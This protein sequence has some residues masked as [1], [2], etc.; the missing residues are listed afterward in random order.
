MRAPEEF[1]RV[2]VFCGGSS[3]EREISLQSGAAVT[4]GLV[5]AGIDTR[6][7]DTADNDID[8][9]TFDRVF[10]ALH[11]R[12]GEDGKIQAVLDYYHIPY[13]GSRVPASALSMNKWYTKSV[14]QSIGVRTPVYRIVGNQ[15]SVD[16]EDVRLPV[17][18]K[19]VNEGSSIGVAH[20][21]EIGQLQEAIS[22]AMQYDEYVL[23]EAAISGKEY[24]YSFIDGVANMPI[25]CLE[26]ATGFYD[27]DAKYLRDDTHYIV[28]PPM[29]E[30]LKNE[31]IESSIA[32]YK[33]IG[34]C[35]WGRVDFMIDEQENIW[36]IEVNSV[37]GMTSHSLVPM[38]ANSV[39]LDFSS[40]CVAI[41]E[42]SMS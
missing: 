20:V 5:S 10:I 41:L 42:S 35:G 21:T 17:Y 11:G 28:D 6:L 38:S 19:P 40:T 23:L 27:Y 9:S 39:G 26:P 2:A 30:M 31:C 29:D 13:T 25:I 12:D 14:W 32:A 18:V 22:A 15:Q 33:S 7:I 34:M 1:G 36:F 24:S 16:I 37:P 8:F 3:R 4:D